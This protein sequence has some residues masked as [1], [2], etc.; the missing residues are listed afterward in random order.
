MY[1]RILVPTDGS[2]VAEAAVDAAITLATRFDADLHIVHVLEAGELPPG[3]EDEGA[4]ESAVRGR[5]AVSSAADRAAAAG[6]DATPTVVDTGGSVPEAICRY[7][8][9]Q[10]CDCIVAGTYGRTGLDRFILGSVAERLLRESPIPVLTVHEETV[11][12]P[13]LDRIL[14]PTDGSACARAAVDQAIELALAT[15]ATLHV[16]HVVDSGIVDTGP[17]PAALEEA[18]ERAIQQV[19]ERAD[20]AGVSAT[21]RSLLNGTPHQEIVDYADEN[22]IECIVMGTHGRTGVDR[23]LLGSV[24][25]RVVRLSDSPVLAV[26]SAD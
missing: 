4:D 24:A 26:K 10:G 25:E 8:D 11:V 16:V 2:E 18:G 3:V 7:A 20:A 22:G 12:D 19:V 1:E 5:E 23:Y 21:E 14:V 15:D 17:I 13:A 9:E 6:V